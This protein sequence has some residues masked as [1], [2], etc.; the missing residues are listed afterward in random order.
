MTPSAAWPWWPRQFRA[1]VFVMS[2]EAILEEAVR[3]A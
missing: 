2:G 3:V 1:P